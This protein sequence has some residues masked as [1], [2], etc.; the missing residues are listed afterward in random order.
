MPCCLP[1]H[2]VAGRSE[3]SGGSK[4]STRSLRRALTQPNDQSQQLQRIND[5]ASVAATMSQPTTSHNEKVRRKRWTMDENKQ[6]LRSYFRVTNLE[7]DKTMYRTKLF[8]DVIDHIPH[9]REFTEQRIADQRRVIILNNLLPNVIVKQIKDEVEAELNILHHTQGSPQPDEES[10]TA[11]EDS[12][13]NGKNESPTPDCESVWVSNYK[14]H[15]IEYRGMDP[16]RRP[17]L[18]KI[19]YKPG[20]NLS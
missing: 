11:S 12:N 8:Q 6:I 15:L 9:L 4:T 19:A 17:R 18:P 5:E 13:N 16:N 10:S 7:T 1:Q 3:D 20:L 14:R 2:A